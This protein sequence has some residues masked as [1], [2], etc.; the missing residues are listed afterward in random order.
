[1]DYITFKDSELNE[2]ITDSIN[3]W[4]QNGDWERMKEDLHYHLFNEDYYIIGTYKAKQ[5]LGDEV[6]E[7][8]E[9]IKEYEKE[10]FGEVSTDFSSAERVVN[11][12]SYI[13]GEE[14]LA[15]REEEKENWRGI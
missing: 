4:K 14:L 7:V 9:Y 6:F 10:Y 11:M 8:I 12:F 2:Y 13:R 3:E 15:D 1:M 5:W